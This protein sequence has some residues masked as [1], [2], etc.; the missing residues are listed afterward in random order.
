MSALGT[1][2]RLLSR[3][4]IISCEPVC[5]RP[6]ELAF[7]NA[8]GREVRRGELRTLVAI[9][10]DKNEKRPVSVY[11]PDIYECAGKATPARKPY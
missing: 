2:P 10:L 5:K 11:E 8:S 4:S 3:G 1:E 7:E 9:T 6:A